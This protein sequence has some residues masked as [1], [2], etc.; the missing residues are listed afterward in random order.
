M[1]LRPWGETHC[2]DSVEAHSRLLDRRNGRPLSPWE[3]HSG[4]GRLV[5]PDETVVEKLTATNG[6]G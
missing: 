4:D 6:G 5:G 2:F 1:A 3:I